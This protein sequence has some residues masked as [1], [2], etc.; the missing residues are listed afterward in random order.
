[1]AT[2]QLKRGTAARLSEVNLVL[3]AGEPC[4]AYDVKKLRIGDGITPW[5][6]LP[7]VGGDELYCTT[8]YEELPSVGTPN[9]IYKVE[10]KKTLYQ[11]NAAE[12]KYEPLSSGEGFDPSQISLINGGSAI[13]D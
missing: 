13:L 10:E 3:A 4:Y 12:A 8:T 9:C 2:L 6:E 11:W 1:M 5:N 7:D